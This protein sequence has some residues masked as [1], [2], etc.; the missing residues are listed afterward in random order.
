VSPIVGRLSRQGHRVITQVS[1]GC[2]QDPAVVFSNC[3]LGP[4][5]ELLVSR[6]VAAK[7]VCEVA[8]AAW[9]EAEALGA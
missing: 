3:R 2:A 6:E 5:A 7:L 1:E 9:P 4:G 8:A